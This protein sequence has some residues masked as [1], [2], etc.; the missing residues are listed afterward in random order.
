[1]TY[2]GL[3]LV[4]VSPLVAF[5]NLLLMK[6]PVGNVNFFPFGAVRSTLRSAILDKNRANVFLLQGVLMIARR[7]RIRGRGV[8]RGVVE[9]WKESLEHNLIVRRSYSSL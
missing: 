8:R 2:E 1:M 7:G 6:R 9:D 5:T 4:T 3:I